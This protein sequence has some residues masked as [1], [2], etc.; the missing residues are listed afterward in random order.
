MKRFI[1]G[2]SINCLI[3]CSF[4]LYGEIQPSLLVDLEFESIKITPENFSSHEVN[5][6]LNK[7]FKFNV[8]PFDSEP[9]EV[10]AIHGL[11]GRENNYDIDNYW[12][13]R[14]SDALSY[15]TACQYFDANTPSNADN[16][17]NSHFVV[18]VG[19]IKFLRYAIS[20]KVSYISDDLTDLPVTILNWGDVGEKEYVENKQKKRN[21]DF[22]N[23][24]TLGDYIHSGAIK[25]V[26]DI[27]LGIGL[28]SRLKGE[29]EEQRGNKINFVFEDFRYHLEIVAQ[30]NYFD[31]QKGVQEAIIYGSVH[32]IE[33]TF[34]KY[35]MCIYHKG[36]DYSKLTEFDYRN[37]EK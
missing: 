25:Q 33:G 4:P 14:T 11:F 15:W 12:Y 16:K 23:G 22:L 17:I 18:S 9:P 20:S 31:Q 37:E 2:F 10:L 28:S 8:Y 26:N 7:T 29:G 5:K 13:L 21:A 1:I 6:L 36:R 34:A 19:T 24:E 27:K 3:L 35:W 30:G 32:A